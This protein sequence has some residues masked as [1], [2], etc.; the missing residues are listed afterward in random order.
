MFDL[1]GTLALTEHRAQ[2]LI[3]PARRR[4]GAALTRLATGTSP[5]PMVRTLLAL[6]NTSA[7]VEIGSGRSD[8]VKD[9]TTTWLADHGLEH[10]PIRTR[11]RAT[12]GP[13]VR[14][15]RIHGGP[16]DVGVDRQRDRRARSQP[17]TR[18]ARR[19]AAARR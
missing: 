2:V 9:T 1:D 10:I 4:T 18:T 7:D 5:H 15:S 17:R 13:A 16:V 6:H 11:P 12:A 19:H 3:V 8:E 14:G